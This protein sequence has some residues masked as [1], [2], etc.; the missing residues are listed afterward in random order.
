MLAG[1]MFLWI[2]FCFS[3]DLFLLSK[4]KVF[5]NRKATSYHFYC[6]WRLS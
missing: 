2:M 3:T 4:G 6:V 1:V 5:C